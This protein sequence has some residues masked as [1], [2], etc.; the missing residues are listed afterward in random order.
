MPPAFRASSFVA[1]SCCALAAASCGDPFTIQA[2]F[3]TVTDSFAIAALTRTP[4]SSRA[5]WRI[6]GFQ[7]YRLD[8]IGQAFD[9]GIDIDPAGVIKVY[10]AR[11]ITVSA[12]GGGASAPPQVGLQVT[13]TAYDAADRAPETGYTLDT[14][15]VVRRGQTVFV[16]STSDFCSLQATGG[17]QLFAKMIIDSVDVNRRQF[18]V[19]STIQPSCN[20]RSF[21]TG[22][23]TF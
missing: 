2:Q 19:R 6:A 3:D 17:T 14:A 10:P 9:I 23:P 16:T 12:A 7:R 15:L 13:T 11:A 5:L 22:R 4:P 8:S 1:L 20:F 21:A 18:F